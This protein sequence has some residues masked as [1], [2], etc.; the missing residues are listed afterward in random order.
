MDEQQ[1]PALEAGDEVVSQQQ[2]AQVEG[3]AAQP[4]GEGEDA[5]AVSASKARRQRRTAELQRAKQAEAEAKREAEALRRQ[6][7]ELKGGNDPAPTREQFRDF[8][9]W[10]AALAA[11]TV[12]SKMTARD[13]AR[14]EKQVQEREAAQMQAAQKA[15]QALAEQWVDQVAD[16]RGRYADFDQVAFTAPISDGVAEMVAQS[17]IGA[18]LAYYLGKNRDTAL[19]ISQ[20]SPVEAA[21]ELGRL[22]ATLSR[23]RPPTQTQ[24]PDPITPVR[25]KATG[26]KDP[27]KMTMEEYRKWREAGGR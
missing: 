12:M 17:E 16:A 3:D 15:K 25:P 1:T 22:E 6:I 27:A 5:E 4:E 2:E 24:A 18:D 9:E 14:I 10:Q 20:L 19:R 11:H 13:E 8:E 26:V 21:R 23:P 7:Q